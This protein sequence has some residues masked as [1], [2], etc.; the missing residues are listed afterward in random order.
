[1]STSL[2]SDL[3]SKPVNKSISELDSRSRNKSSAAHD[4]ISVGPFSVFTV[5]TESTALQPNAAEPN[6]D[7]AAPALDDTTEVTAP[8]IDSFESPN[9]LHD[10]LDWQDLFN[11]DYQFPNLEANDLDF[12]SHLDEL[13]SGE[14]SS[15]ALNVLQHQGYPSLHDQSESAS[16][17]QN[18][19]P[20]DVQMLLDHFKR[21]V[22]P[23]LVSIPLGGKSVWDV[24]V[25]N[26]AILTLA[27]MTYMTAEITSRAELATLLA[28]CATAAIHLS[29]QPGREGEHDEQYWIEFAAQSIHEARES[30]HWSL[31]H[32]TK[33][34]KTAKYK[35]Q[36]MANFAVINHATLYDCQQEVRTGML[37]LERLLRFRG[38]AKPYISRKARLLHHLY[39]WIRVVNE[40]TYV[41][42]DHKNGR[43]LEIAKISRK[44]GKR[45]RGE[46]VGEDTRHH[47]RTDES[48]PRLDDFLRLQPNVAEVEQVI[49]SQKDGEASIRDVHYEDSSDRKGTLYMHLYGISENWLSLVSQTTRLAN[50][51][52]SFKASQERN[53]DILDSLER[54]KSKLEQMVCSFAMGDSN[55]DRAWNATIPNETL[56]SEP[57]NMY[58]ELRSHM[59]KAFNSSLMIFFY[60]RIRDVSPWILQEHVE[61]VI[62]ALK[63]F[64]TSCERHCMDGPGSPWPTFIAGCEAMSATQREYFK[65]WFDS[66]FE[67]TGFTRFQT[68]KACMI[69]VWER[70][71]A[72]RREKGVGRDL[73][74]SWIP[75]LREKRVFVMLA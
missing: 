36:L 30:L 14:Q 62:R 74:Y 65:T 34:P 4:G 1:M 11:L 40:S 28:T 18:L 7:A 67:L 66:A 12:P 37:E 6:D 43:P 54:R 32:E 55:S 33:G 13:A 71:D 53:I 72:P 61:K 21:R 42:H 52:D 2:Q 75:L 63:D 25:V 19:K 26:S 57:A 20:A 31:Q 24:T 16:W 47:D 46:D 9:D 59:I 5:P 17:P 22:L 49:V 69:E 10:W 35:D 58:A 44:T 39:S 50:V 56:S 29:A 8:S 27:K 60:R 41:L 15:Q 64:Q 48:N 45:R 68:A 73:I 51:L 3:A 23:Q 38:L 70:R